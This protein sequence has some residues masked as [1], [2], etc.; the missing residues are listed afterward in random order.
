MPTTPTTLL[1]PRSLHNACC[2]TGPYRSLMLKDR[3]CPGMGCQALLGS[4]FFMLLWCT[5]RMVKDAA[6][7]LLASL[8]YD[9]VL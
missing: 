7:Y 9:E 1:A 6:T 5:A 2:S 8:F 4:R 3:L